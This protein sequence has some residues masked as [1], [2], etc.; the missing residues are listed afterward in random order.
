MQGL[1]AELGGTGA[2]YHTGGAVSNAE[3]YDPVLNSWSYVASM[4][5]KRHHH[6]L[7]VMSGKLFAVGGHDGAE[8]AG[9]VE[10]YAPV[11]DSWAD[12]PAMALETNPGD[13]VIF[14]QGTKHSAWGGG[15]RRRMFTINCTLRCISNSSRASTA[16][17]KAGRVGIPTCSIK[18]SCVAPVPPCMPSITATSAPAFT[19][20]AVSYTHLTLPTNREV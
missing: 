9:S 16:W 2:R 13:V 1:V 4:V 15:K 14:N 5:T 3:A 10:A 19:A 11:A 20:N 7:F 17:R 18:T 12:V 8:W 6:S